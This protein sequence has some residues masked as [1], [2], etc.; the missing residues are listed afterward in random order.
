MGPMLFGPFTAVRRA[1]AE[2]FANQE[3]D[4][5]VAAHWWRY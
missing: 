1:E 4:E 3:P 5:I 2:A